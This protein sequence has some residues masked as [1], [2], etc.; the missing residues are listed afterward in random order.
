[1]VLPSLDELCNKYLTFVFEKVKEVLDE[2]FKTFIK[3]KS[4]SVGKYIRKIQRKL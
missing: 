3:N 1:M 2:V 4:V